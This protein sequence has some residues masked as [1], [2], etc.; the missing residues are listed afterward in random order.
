MGS[1]DGLSLLLT[2]KNIDENALRDV[3]V[4]IPVSDKLEFSTKY[5]DQD[6]T[7]AEYVDKKDN[8]VI[9][10]ISTIESGKEAKIGLKLIIK[11]ISKADKNV[12]ISQYFIANINNRDYISNSIEKTA[13]N[14][15]KHFDIKLSSNVRGETVQDEQNIIY[16][17]DVKNNESEELTGVLTYEIPYELFV[18]SI[19]KGNEEIQLDTK[20]LTDS[21]KLQSGEAL[22][23][24]IDGTLKTEYASSD[25]I[26]SVVQIEE[27]YITVKSNELT[28]KIEQEQETE[29][30]EEQGEQPS[31]ETEETK[32][33][34]KEKIG[35]DTEQ[36]NKSYSISGVAFE[37]VNENGMRDNKE[38]LISGMTVLLMDES[39]GKIA[40]NRENK[41][42]ETTTDSNGRYKF[43][44]LTEGKYTVLFKFD[45]SNYNVTEYKKAGIDET[46]NSNVVYKDISINNSTSAYA[47]TETLNLLGDDLANINAGFVKK[48]KFDLKLDKTITKTIVQNGEGTKETSY[49]GTKLAKVE[50]RAK[51]LVNTTMIVEYTI[52]VTNEGELE[53]YA[54][55]IIDY[56]PNGLKFSS[57]MNKNWYQ[58]TDGNLL[59]RELANTIINPGETK[60]VKLTLTKNMTTSNIGTFMN[61]AEINK[62]S[63]RNSAPDIDSTPGN[64]D[65]KED[66]YSTAELIISIGTG[67]VVTNIL[68]IATIIVVMGVGTFIIK[69]KVLNRENY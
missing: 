44:N 47:S 52:K 38:S 2:I 56:I 14:N 16:Y 28:Y 46:N 54:S 49:E 20:T 25:E 1:G 37:D 5:I 68:I 61:S 24:E 45:S 65:L 23:Y 6:Y 11:D 13:Y 18:S 66:D 50:I 64:R 48:K 36:K 10:N 39:T 19:K 9:F 3:K 41:N 29:S 27:T 30:R 31:G 63:N 53:G 42:M 17:I 26:T 58:G 55:E 33:D 34:G 40:L 32:E 69:K 4:T 57:E 67:S 8:N 43:A 62:I 35:K 12:N 22:R 7:D 21:I 51:Q 59:N 60:N 15:S